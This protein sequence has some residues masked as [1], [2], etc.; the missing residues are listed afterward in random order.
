MTWLTRMSLLDTMEDLETPLLAQVSKE[1][2]ELAYRMLTG[3]P[4]DKNYKMEDNHPVERMWGTHEVALTAYCAGASAE[5]NRRG[6]GNGLHL[7][8]GQLIESLRREEPAEFAQPP[9]LFDTDLL[10]SHRS[11]MA[12]RWPEQYGRKWSGTPERWPYLWAFATDEDGSYGLF[13]SGHDKALLKAGERALP[14]S[15]KDRIENL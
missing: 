12:R 14:K 4:F 11:N 7:A 10:R 13:L 8:M 5:L 6:V 1:S 15:V 3:A 2:H 9:W